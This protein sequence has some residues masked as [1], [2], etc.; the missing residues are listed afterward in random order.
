LNR[1]RKPL[2]QFFKRAQINRS[3]RYQE[4]IATCRNQLLLSPKHL[5]KPPF[6]AGAL[7]RVANRSDRSDD[8]NSRLCSDMVERVAPNALA[9]LVRPMINPKSE[10][11]P[12]GPSPQ[13]PNG[14]DVVLTAQM[15]LG[16]EPHGKGKAATRGGEDAA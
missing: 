9:R 10:Q 13:F 8:A 12:I 11:P 15:L 7:N 3:A 16:S 14:A 6:G 1:R 4:Q 5:A 2:F